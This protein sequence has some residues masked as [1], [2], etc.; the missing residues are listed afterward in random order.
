MSRDYAVMGFPV[1][2]S[3]SP[4]IHSIFASQEKIKVHYEKIEV[5]SGSFSDAADAFFGQGGLGLNVTVPF[6]VDAYA[7]AS[8]LNDLAEQAGAVNTLA[9]GEGGLV[10]GHNTDGLGLVR[11]L[12]ARHGWAL[13]G[14]RLMIL[15]A[16]GATRGVIVPLLARGVEEIIIANRTVDKAEAL[17]GLFST[18]MPGAKLSVCSLA[19]AAECEADVVINGTS[20]GLSS[21]DITLAPELVRGRHCYDM[22]YGNNARF[23]HWASHQGAISAVDGLGMLIE[24]AA[25]SFA[26]WHQVRPDTNLAFAKIREQIG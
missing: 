17:V 23:A 6:K 4:E 14:A 19:D 15:G 11:D 26:I 3:L 25:E 16:G 1:S 8:R 20:L 10:S 5:S 9:R 12:E 7:Y 21:G 2:H 13:N 24:Q 22:S 18:L